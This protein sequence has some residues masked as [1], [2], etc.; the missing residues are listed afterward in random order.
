MN[1]VLIVDDDPA[2]RRL[3]AKAVSEVGLE[4]HLCSDGVHALDALQ[5]NQDYCLLIADISMPQMDGREL[6]E[7]I[8]AENLAPGLPIIIASGVVGV[9]EISDLL[10]VGAS[11]FLPKPFEINEVMNQIRRCVD[12]QIGGR[13]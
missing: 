11:L 8:H 9:R 7:T 10:K 5:C 12:C 6:I 3:M 1:R 13:R 4:Y 2:A